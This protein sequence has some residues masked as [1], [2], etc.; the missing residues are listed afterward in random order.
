MNSLLPFAHGPNHDC[1]PARSEPAVHPVTVRCLRQMILSR[2]QGRGAMPPRLGLDRPVFEGVMQRHFPRE[3]FWRS[4]RVLL[5]DDP[6]GSL[7]EE[8]LDDLLMAHRSV[9]AATAAWVARIIRVGCQGRN[10]LWEDLGLWSRSELGAL[11]TCNFHPLVRKNRLDMKWK[12]FLYKQLCERSGL[13][14]C[15]VPNCCQCSDYPACFGP[16]G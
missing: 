10:H 9:D 14:T 3:R 11:L 16:E 13:R 6:G 2:E 15:K 7:E 8:E 12:N 1:P 4:P 5:G